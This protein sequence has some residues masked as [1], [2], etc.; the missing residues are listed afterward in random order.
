MSGETSDPASGG[1]DV[2]RADLWLWAVRLFKTRNLAAGACRKGQVR[3]Q[4]HPIKPARN[5]RVGDELH[6]ERD[7]LTAHYRIRA[8]LDQRVGAKLVNDYLEDLT[9]EEER[10]KAKLLALQNRPLVR[11]SDGKGRPTKKD[12][13]EREQMADLEAEPLETPEDLAELWKKA[14]R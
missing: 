7:Y 6:V 12:R 10:E 11:Q 4:G 5:L 9:T 8:L 2:V 1:L 3:I 13:R 14:I